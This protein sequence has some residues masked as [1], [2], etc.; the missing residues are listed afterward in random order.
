MTPESRHDWKIQRLEQRRDRGN[1]GP[2][3]LLDL[4]EAYFQKGYYYGAGQDW[5][6]RAVET[7]EG[8][9]TTYGGGARAYNILANAAY[10]LA[11]LDAAEGWY[12]KAIDAEPTDALAHV[13][14]GNLHKQRGNT[15]RAI[16][17]FTRA[18]ELDPDL[19]QAHYNL[20]GALYAEA[21]ERDFRGA[22]DVMERAI[23]HLVTALRLRPF[24]SFVGNIYKDLGELFLHT[25]QY[26]YAR[27]FFT[28]LRQHPEYGPLAHYYLGL[29]HF[30]MGRYTNSIQHYREFL[31]HEPESA[32]A[33][34]KI[35]LAWLE[36]GNWDRARE[37]CEYALAVERDHLLARFSLGC[38]DLDQRLYGQAEE[39][40]ETILRQAPDYF[41]AYVELVK[42]HYIRG[43]FGWLFDQLRLEVRAFE[44]DESF[45]GGRQFYKGTRGRT[46]RKID[47][48]LQ[49][50]TEMG[51][52]AFASLAEVVESVK[53]DSLRFQV[54][55]Q[56]YELSR[57]HRVEQVLGQ[58]EEP[59]DHFGRKL[60]RTVL[61][62]SQY[63]PEEA[64]L[65][66]F[67]VDEAALK[68][69]AQQSK[70]KS[71]DITDYHAALDGAKAQLREYQAYLLLALAVKGTP[72]AED[73]LTDFL[74]SEFRELKAS[75]A[76]A[77]LF[78]GNEDA[79][80]YLEDETGGLPDE[81]SARLRELIA[82][83]EERNL[84]EE[85]IIDLTQAAQAARER[86]RSGRSM[87]GSREACSVCAR[88]HSEVDRLMSGNRVYICNLCVSYVH[89]HRD[90]QAVPDKEEHLCSFCGSSVF[91]V[92]G[93][94]EANKLLI[95]NRCLDTC[96][97]V[98]AREEVE[99]FLQGFQ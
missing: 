32:L 39:R 38:I 11:D 79:I 22:D 86:P 96:V 37:A 24:E 50:I 67:Y 99:Q 28:R 40:F 70:P 53:T 17:A 54:W 46:R 63:V 45:D 2:E 98:L 52:T 34:S 21:R 75:S 89:Q 26:K 84:A 74:E 91:E 6:R 7:A 58:L 66:A 85:K 3:L 23:Y 27:R 9:I 57:R 51:I 31:K 25:R 87:R 33:W 41:P 82:M 68:R 90:D 8:V 15:G 60:G 19:W 14:L 36:L 59:G 73:F 13:G 65:D 64:I 44:E 30:S 61:L 95:C 12:A 49:Q 93:M 42:S 56:L 94:Y 83:G 48:L 20:G 62:L 72:T 4:A 77:L 43:D 1:S 97:G 5:F 69:R 76:I 16:D 47:V 55:E 92:E 71:D 18:T 10:G 29:T 35:A 78:Y 88:H 81:Q 80:R